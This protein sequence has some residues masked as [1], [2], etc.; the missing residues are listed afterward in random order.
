MRDIRALSSNPEVNQRVNL[1]VCARFVLL[2]IQHARD[3]A[4]DGKKDEARDWYRFFN[5]SRIVEVLLHEQVP[6]GA[7]EIAFSLRELQSEVHPQD[8]PNYAT[9]LQAIRASLQ[10]IL[11]RIPAKNKQQAEAA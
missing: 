4:K 9:D 1:G 2:Y 7:A 5:N 11:D 8:V 3:L 6:E 10:E